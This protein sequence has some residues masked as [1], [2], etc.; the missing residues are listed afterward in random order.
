MSTL[1]LD[2]IKALMDKLPKPE[3][4][5][6]NPFRMPMRLAGR[7]IY[8]EPPP[9]PKIQVHQIFLKDGTPLLPEAFLREQNAR[10]AAD[11]GYRDA[12]CKDKMFLLGSYGILMSAQHRH[13][14]TSIVS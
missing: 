13:M 2:A 1:T 11:F 3:P 7:D 4:D 10:W 5:L 6:F 14:I 8:E 9:P 12:L